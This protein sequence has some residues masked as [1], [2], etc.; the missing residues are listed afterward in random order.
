MQWQPNRSLPIS[1]SKQISEWMIKQIQSGEWPIE[2]KLPPQRQLALSL[3][4]NRSTLQEAIDDLKADGLLSSRAG[5]ATF[6]TNDSWNI[7]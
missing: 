6:V 2:T 5:S 4:V 3:G 7:F 1:L